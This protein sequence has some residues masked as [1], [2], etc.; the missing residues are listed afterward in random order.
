VPRALVTGANGFIGSHLVR[1]LLDRGY[2][3]NCL[4]R[5]TSD[6]RSLAGLPVRLFIGDVRDPSSLV[7]PLQNVDYVFHL[8]AA[9]LVTSQEEFDETNT[10]GTLNLL[11]AAAAQSPQQL[12]RFLYAS[13]E[14]AV[15]PGQDA[16]ALD[17]SAPLRPISWYGESKKNAEAH[18]RS[19]GNELPWTIVRFSSVYGER[20]QDISQ[21]FPAIEKGLLP[22]IGVE[23]KATVL[24]YVRDVVRAVV[25]AAESPNT[26]GE[27]Y[28]I[29]HPR[30]WSAEDVTRTIAAA[31]GHPDGLMFPVPTALLQLVAPLAEL[32]H[33]FDRQRPKLTRDKARELSQRFWVIDPAKAKRDFGWEAA[34][35]LPEGMR[36]TT[37][38]WLE[39]EQALRDMAQEKQPTLWLK[40]LTCAIGLGCLIELTSAT[41]KFYTFKPR[42]GAIPVILGGFGLGL[43]T[44][45]MKTR[46]QSDLAQ[47]A[48][49]TL[50]AT[51]AELLNQL[52]LSP[53]LSWRFAPGWPFG[54]RSAT[55][56]TFVL[57]MAGGGFV[58][59]V[60]A[61]MRADYARRLRFG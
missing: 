42:W 37:A 44:A 18:V 59:V 8:A 28:H 20:E 56:R 17:E 16:T 23:E 10:Q 15:G 3:V 38:Y 50:F 52:G 2:E 29:A 34:F 26:V 45:S 11:K 48:V 4:V 27:I 21:A 55:L 47:F 5:A 14:A 40:Y 22:K 60:N 43:G 24:V 32:I 61:I 19:F 6:L 36:R 12:K 30:V 41:G 31:M 46:R 9:L 54:I 35:D 58:L 51:T 25:D 33:E 1:E 53:G 39:Q 57:G 49:G 13:S 7:A